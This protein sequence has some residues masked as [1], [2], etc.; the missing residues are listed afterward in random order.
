[1]LLGQAES[2]KSTL[3]KQFQLLYAASSLDHERPSWRPV[4]FFNVI[5][6]IRMIVDELNTPSPKS[7]AGPWE[8]A[9]DVDDASFS[10]EGTRLSEVISDLAQD[11]HP[12]IQLEDKLASELSG[13]VKVSG[14][15]TGVFVRSG[16]Q[17]SSGFHLEHVCNAV[18]LTHRRRS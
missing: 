4:V 13:G 5:K 6:A 15:K 17:V 7:P 1:M 14:G 3:Q 11:L 2:G 12:L 18:N 9:M 10:S 16:W 8:M